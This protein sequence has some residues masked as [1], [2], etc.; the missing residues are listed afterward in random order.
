MEISADVWLILTAGI[1]TVLTALLSVFL[2]INRSVPVNTAK[3]TQGSTAQGFPPCKQ[4]ENSTKE[5]ISE[6]S[7]P[8]PESAWTPQTAKDHPNDSHTSKQRET[9]EADAVSD[10]DRP[11][12]CVKT[13]NED[14]P[15]RY[16]PGMLRTSQL[17]KMMSKEELEEEQRVQREQLAAIFNLLKQ[18]RDTFGEVSETDMEEQ[19]K[20]YSI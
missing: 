11:T 12:G 16:M 14:T 9:V 6:L 3:G 13:N 20:L 18:N 19:L 4:Q 7:E 17:E 8:Q 10:Y 2:F 1:I 5:S 15:L